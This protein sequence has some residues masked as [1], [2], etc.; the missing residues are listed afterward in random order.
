MRG[1]HGV[2]AKR[3]RRESNREI[4]HAWVGIKLAGAQN[5]RVYMSGWSE[6]NWLL[7]ERFRDSCTR[8][9]D[10]KLTNQRD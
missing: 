7:R 8:T 1:C 2:S 6:G 3:V 5:E 10:I 4:A 9:R